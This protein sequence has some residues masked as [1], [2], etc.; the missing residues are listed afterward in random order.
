MG[1]ERLFTRTWDVTLPQ[2]VW[3]VTV[4]KLLARFMEEKSVQ[5]Y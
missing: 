2:V 5:G 3:D 1:K 4:A